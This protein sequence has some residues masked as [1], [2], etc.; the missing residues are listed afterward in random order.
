MKGK[1]GQ[2]RYSSS[3]SGVDPKR[4]IGVTRPPR[5]EFESAVVA[6][7]YDSYSDRNSPIAWPRRVAPSTRIATPLGDIGLVGIPTCPLPVLSN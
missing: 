6:L 1:T 7:R 3:P 2:N 5:V 4:G